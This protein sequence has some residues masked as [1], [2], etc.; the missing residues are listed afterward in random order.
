MGTVSLQPGD[1][2][3]QVVP[4]LDEHH[5]VALSNDAAT[6]LSFSRSLVRSLT[7]M[8]R[9][10]VIEIDGSACTDLPSF[11]RE[12]ER[13][14]P[15]ARG[16]R[17]SWW[18]DLHSLGHALRAP[19]PGLHCRYL[20]WRDADVLLQHDAALFGGLLN[21]LFAAAADSEYISLE[22]VVV[23][24]VVLLGGEKLGTYAENSD[25]PLNRW[26]VDDD[27][28]E[29]AAD[30]VRHGE[31]SFWEVANVVERPPVLTLRLDG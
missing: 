1:L 26:H 9:T 10:Q 15:P 18:R 6:R 29:P 24:R 27:R 13:N 17:N 7:M 11:C 4:L 30:P 21:A 28:D 22:P 3:D 20:L 19:A 31:T 16:R 8:P 14:L 5:L 12:L 25:G 2:I 23:Q